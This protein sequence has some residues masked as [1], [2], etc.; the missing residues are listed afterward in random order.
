MSDAREPELC[1][2]ARESLIKNHKAVAEGTSIAA[3]YR[4]GEK[5]DTEYP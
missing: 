4:M 5:P 1:R 2:S 3:A